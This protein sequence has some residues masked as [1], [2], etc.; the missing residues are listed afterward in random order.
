MPQPLAVEISLYP[1]HDDYKSPIL[2]FIRALRSHPELDVQTNA[3]STQV[4]G[5][6]DVI[7]P[8]LGQEL[9][10]CFGESWTSVAVLKLVGADLG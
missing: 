5:D 6:F 3:M 7:W 10:R 9:K 1:L 8:I 2:E 4:M